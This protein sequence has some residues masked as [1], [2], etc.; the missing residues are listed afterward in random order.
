MGLHRDDCDGGGVEDKS[1]GVED[2][3]R[4]RAGKTGPIDGPLLPTSAAATA[5]DRA[6]RQLRLL[7]TTTVL[8]LTVLLEPSTTR[9]GAR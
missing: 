2:A 5:G 3:R 4:V 7:S 9:R 1:H 6:S 8:S